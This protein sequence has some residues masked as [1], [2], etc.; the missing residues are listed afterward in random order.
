MGNKAIGLLCVAVLLVVGGTGCTAVW[1]GGG[2]PT[3][4]STASAV[5]MP[6]PT[7]TSTPVPSPTPTAMSVP[8]TPAPTVE[9]QERQEYYYEGSS[10]VSD[11]CMSR[12]TP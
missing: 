10:D 6:A 1:Q 11:G 8:T 7:T 2:Q 3:T 4:A 12:W 9:I 5:A